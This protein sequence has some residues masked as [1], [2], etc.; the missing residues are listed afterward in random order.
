MSTEHLLRG[1]GDVQ[2]AVRVFIGTA[3]FGQRE[4]LTGH[5]AAID[6]EVEG[7]ALLQVEPSS[8]LGVYRLEDCLSDYL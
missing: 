7:L 8:A 4:G 1:V 5:G 2:E 3:D 6:Y